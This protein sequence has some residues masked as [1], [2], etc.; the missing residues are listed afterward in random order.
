MIPNGNVL[1]CESERGRVFEIA[2]DGTPVWA[3]WNPEFDGDARKRIYRI[4]RVSLAV[5]D[6]RLQLDE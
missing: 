6:T 3:F 1:I 5:I 4:H 2:G